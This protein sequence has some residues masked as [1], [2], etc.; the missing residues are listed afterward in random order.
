MIN[1]KEIEKSGGMINIALEYKINTLKKQLNELSESSIFQRDT[2][3]QEIAKYEKLLEKRR[4][5]ND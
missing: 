4:T 2:L 5:K 3:E 1:K